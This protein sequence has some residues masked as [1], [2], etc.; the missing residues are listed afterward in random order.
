MQDNKNLKIALLF[1]A[2]G[3]YS[4]QILGF[5]TIIILARLLSPDEIGVYAVAGT[6]SIIASELSSFGVVQYLIREKNIHENKI[7]SVLG[8]AIMV[9]LQHHK[10]YP[11]ELSRVS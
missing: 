7:R 11:T 4:T 3:Q 9:Y 5:V 2:I 1:S 6:A 8:M 10:A